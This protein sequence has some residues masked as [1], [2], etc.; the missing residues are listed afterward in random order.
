MRFIA[1]LVILFIFLSGCTR[2]ETGHTGVR[3]NFNGEIEQ[4][5]RGVG[6][7]QTLF[8]HLTVYTSNQMTIELQGLTPQTK[9]RSTLQDL[10]LAFTYT[11]EP[12]AIPAM[13]VKF[14]GRDLTHGED[15]YPL[16]NYVSSVVTTAVTSAVSE[17]E[18]LEANANRE[19]IRLSIIAK[20]KEILKEEKLDDIIR[21]H[22]VFVKNLLLAPELRASATATIAAQNDLI[23]KTTEVAS[24]TKDAQKFAA[25]STPANI[26]YMNAKANA[27]IA[28]A[29][30][31]GK[32]NTMIIPYNFNGMINLK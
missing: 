20:A 15:I 12:S 18:A 6:W 23:R 10:D 7:H 30:K 25:L 14:K 2:V 4:T 19:K 22:Q 3:T 11:I 1:T 8:G 9:D 24:A 17:Y 5:A 26:A 28:E 21:I 13:V 29:V 31:A 32:V 16:G 27:D